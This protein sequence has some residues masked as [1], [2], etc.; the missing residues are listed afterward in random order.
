MN[1]TCMLLM[2][3]FYFQLGQMSFKASKVSQKPNDNRISS[4]LFGM[5]ILQEE[6]CRSYPTANNLININTLMLFTD[7][8]YI[9]GL[10][11]SRRGLRQKI[12]ALR[13]W[14]PS[15]L[16]QGE[17]NPKRMPTSEPCIHF[18]SPFFTSP[19]L[20][21]LVIPVQHG[22]NGF[23]DF[24]VSARGSIYEFIYLRYTTYGALILKMMIPITSPMIWTNMRIPRMIIL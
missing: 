17:T 1:R 18:F 5:I 24:E 23:F 21:S 22:L 14:H 13:Q 10:E 9:G 6:D 3:V 7:M 4:K 2:K 19:H 11:Q 16:V 8:H 12:L 20:Y 15:P